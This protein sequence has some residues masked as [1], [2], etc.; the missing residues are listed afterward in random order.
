VS[1]G[2]ARLSPQEALDHQINGALILDTRS[3]EEFHKGFIK[4]SIF[5]G[6]DGGFAPWVGT[7]LLDHKQPIVILSEPGREEEVATRLARVGFD[8]S[9]GYIDGGY[10]A[11]KDSGLETD[12]IQSLS[13][14]EVKRLSESAEINLIDSRKPSEFESKRAKIAKNNPL[15]FIHDQLDRYNKDETYYVHCRSGYRSLIYTSILKKNGINDVVDVD[16]GFVAM[17]N[18]EMEMLDFSCS[19]GN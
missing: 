1:S 11:W 10:Q 17:E 18:T 7:V 4:D 12:L 3:K 16:G 14:E 19:A 2:T 5:I 13:A 8:N 6:I 15:D 9:I